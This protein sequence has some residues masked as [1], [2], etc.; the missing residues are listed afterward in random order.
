LPE[1]KVDVDRYAEV[2]PYVYHLTDESNLDRI[3]KE[4]GLSCAAVLMKRARRTDL[5]RTRRQGHK[6]IEV[7]GSTVSLRDQKPL[8]RGNMKLTGEFTF[9][10]FVEALNARVFFWPGKDDG[11]IPPGKNHFARYASERPALLRCQFQSLMFAN[12]SLEP[13]FCPYNSGAPRVV[14]GRKSPRGPGT[15]LKACDFP[16]P[17]SRVVEVTFIGKVVLPRDAELGRGPLG[18]WQSFFAGVE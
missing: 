11:P 6:P 13:L 10:D 7:D 1:V 4:K 16:R 2:R 5:L 8:F 14:N 17:A 9:E 3:G 18:P 15:F 12:P